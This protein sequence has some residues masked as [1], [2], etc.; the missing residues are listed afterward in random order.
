M[1]DI[2]YFYVAKLHRD[3]NLHN[4]QKLVFFSTAYCVYY[5]TIITNKR[6]FFQNAEADSIFIEEALLS[7]PIK[8]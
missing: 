6:E 2:I 4:T 1:Y 8:V 3:Y 5:L 7:P